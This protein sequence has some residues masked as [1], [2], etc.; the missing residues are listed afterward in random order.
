MGCIFGI[1]LNSYVDRPLNARWKK[2]DKWS[3]EVWC[4]D[5]FCIEMNNGHNCRESICTLAVWEQAARREAGKKKALQ[6]YE[7]QQRVAGWRITWPKNNFSNNKSPPPHLPPRPASD[8]TCLAYT[9]WSGGS[10]GSL[11]SWVKPRKKRVQV[12]ADV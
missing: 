4:F 5:F 7:W 12:A 1:I 9:E 2:K 10:V 8:T 3:S 11:H 6:Q